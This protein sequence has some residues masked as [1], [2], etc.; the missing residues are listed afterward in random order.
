MLLTARRSSSATTLQQNTH[1]T[2]MTSTLK[3]HQPNPKVTPG[4]V[5]GLQ[6]EALHL[7]SAEWMPW[8][9]RRRPVIVRTS[10]RACA[11]LLAEAMNSLT[12]SS[13]ASWHWSAADDK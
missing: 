6:S 7:R 13:H 12:C 5:S 1:A 10:P 3:L 8:S 4:Q 11:A 2:W 9:G